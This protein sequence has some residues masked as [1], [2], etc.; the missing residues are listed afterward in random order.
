MTEGLR[1]FIEKNIDL[2]SEGQFSEIYDK[3][4]SFRFRRMFTE[5]MLEA[6]INPLNYMTIVPR[7][8]LYQSELKHIIIPDGV[9]KVGNYAFAG[10][11]LEE[12]TLPEGVTYIG[13]GAFMNCTALK[14]LHLPSTLKQID[15]AAF[16]WCRSLEEVTFAGT[17]KQ[18]IN[19]DDLDGSLLRFE[20]VKCSDN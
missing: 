18:W 8:Y 5:A 20:P 4:A 2:I 14:T 6:D 1:K 17:V 10:S 9:T 12:V 13:E 3:I 11:K 7:R 16:S 19:V 15:T